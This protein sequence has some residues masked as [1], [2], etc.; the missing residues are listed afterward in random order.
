MVTK[1]DLLEEAQDLGLDIDPKTKKG[2]I[3]AQIDNHKAARTAVSDASQET[4]G[5]DEGYR[6]AAG[7]SYGV[8]PDDDENVVEDEESD[9]NDVDTSVPGYK[10]TE[11]D[12][13][14]YNAPVSPKDYVND[15]T[16]NDNELDEAG[17][18][19]L[20]E[21]LSRP[22]YGVTARVIV[23]TGNYVKIKFFRNN[24][25]FAIYK[26]RLFDEGDAQAYIDSQIEQQGL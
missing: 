26:S 10:D 20:A 11:R 13:K 18:T 1:A 19:E 6:E 4:D 22:E 3:Q 16:N 23:S 21:S 2:D 12:A 8:A 25:P 9:D 17:Q 15:Q 7:Y 5:V 14:V 24:K